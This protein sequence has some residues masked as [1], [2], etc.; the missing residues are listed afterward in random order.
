MWLHM[1][2]CGKVGVWESKWES[3]TLPYMVNKW[4]RG[5]P[6]SSSAVESSITSPVDS[7]L[8]PWQILKCGVP[9]LPILFREHF[10]YY[11]R[12]WAAVFFVKEF[13]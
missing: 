11:L 13:T 2:M 10:C 1:L 6:A 9:M 7:K 12:P 3:T 8:S 5:H 4:G